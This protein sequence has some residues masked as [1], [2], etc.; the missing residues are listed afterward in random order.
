MC[1]LPRHCRVVLLSVGADIGDAL[2]A[3]VVGES[4]CCPEAVH[5]AHT[6]AH[7]RVPVTQEDSQEAKS[8]KG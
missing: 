5:S 6:T 3:L 4:P 1:N 7:A 2:R 8:A